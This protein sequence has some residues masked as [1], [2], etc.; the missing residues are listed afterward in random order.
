MRVPSGPSLRA[1]QKQGWGA[2]LQRTPQPAMLWGQL[3][4]GGQRVSEPGHRV[5]L[6][7][8]RW[9]GRLC[10]AWMQALLCQGWLCPGRSAEAF[11]QRTLSWA[12][13]RRGTSSR[14]WTGDPLAVFAD[15]DFGNLGRVR[16]G[17]RQSSLRRTGGT[18]ACHLDGQ[19]PTPLA[20][21]ADTGSEH[22]DSGT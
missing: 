20:S 11:T 15:V 13:H 5:A 14:S 12:A 17:S 10:S 4:R 18:R 22:P 3:L 16:R 2:P 7:A 6:L 9:P 8:S 19:L 1:V 21:P